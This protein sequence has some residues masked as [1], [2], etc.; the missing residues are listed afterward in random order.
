MRFAFRLELLALSNYLNKTLRRRRSKLFKDPNEPVLEYYTPMLANTIHVW[1]TDF[2]HILV[3]VSII[4]MGIIT[5]HKPTTYIIK[6]NF[7]YNNY[8]DAYS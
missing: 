3:V 1:R 8:V 2:S 6:N 7:G 5:V 4:Y